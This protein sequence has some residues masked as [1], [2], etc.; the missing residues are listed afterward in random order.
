LRRTPNTDVSDHGGTDF[1]PRIA[2]Y[3]PLELRVYKVLAVQYECGGAIGA[4]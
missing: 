1:F 2:L 3:E 4:Q